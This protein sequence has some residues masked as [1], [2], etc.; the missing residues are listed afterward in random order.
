MQ[1]SFYISECKQNI[2]FSFV[3]NAHV[4]SLT[5]SQNLDADLSYCTA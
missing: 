3:Y 1:V 2:S 4:T 5:T